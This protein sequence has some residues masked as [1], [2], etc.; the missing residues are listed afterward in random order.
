MEARCSK[1]GSVN[2]P[3]NKFCAACGSKFVAI[4]EPVSAGEDGLYYCYRHRK[5]TTRVTCGR[6]ERPLCHKCMVVGANGVRCP[7]CA[8]NKVPVRLGGVVHD[9]AKGVGRVT[10]TVGSR[11]IWYLYLWSII[12]RIIMGFF[13]R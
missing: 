11:P 1:C 13:G 2:E 8:R 10:N 4:P 9:A 5:E 12:V 3:A 7:D 6:C